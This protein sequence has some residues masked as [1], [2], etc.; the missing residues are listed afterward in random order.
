MSDP[1]NK[2]QWPEGW[3]NGKLTIIVPLDGVTRSSSPGEKAAAAFKRLDPLSELITDDNAVQTLSFEDV[4]SN[5]DPIDPCIPLS[6][7]RERLLSDEAVEAA[8]RELIKHVPAVVVKTL[9]PVLRAA[10]DA[11]FP[12]EEKG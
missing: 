6:S 10:L 5:G 3:V 1:L 7:I 11:A 8:A 2:G 9:R 4:Q 12:K